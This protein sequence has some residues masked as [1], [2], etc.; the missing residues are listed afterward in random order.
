MAQ[1]GEV[2]DDQGGALHVVVGHGVVR[3]DDPWRPMTTTGT[4]VPTR[5]RWVRD[6]TGA[7]RMMP[8][9]PR[10]IIAS[11]T[12]ASSFSPL[13]PGPRNTWYSVSASEAV[14]PSRI[15]GKKGLRMSGSITPMVYVCPRRLL[16][17]AFG[18]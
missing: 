6:D 8:S 11:V 2:A 5:S 17:P 15:S 1:G 13:Q 9:M 12:R 3:G 10:S 16:A 4:A 18:R 14:T 7:T